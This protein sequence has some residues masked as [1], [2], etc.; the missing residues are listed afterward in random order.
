MNWL[1][2]LASSHFM[3]HGTSDTLAPKIL[4]EG[5]VPGRTLVWDQERAKEDE[6][7]RASYGGVYF[8]NNFMTA[9]SA[10]HTAVEQFGGKFLLV[11]A[12]LELRTPSILLDEDKLSNPIRAFNETL[13]VNANGW[14]YMDWVSAEMPDLDK[15]VQTYLNQISKTY[16]SVQKSSLGFQD[17]R[18]FEA[19][20]PQ[21][22]DF[23]I[24]AVMREIAI[25]VKRELKQGGYTSLLYRFPQFKDIDLSTQET[26]YRR[27]AN[28]LMQKTNFMANENVDSF[29]HNV[30][31]LDPVSFSGKNK[32]VLVSRIHECRHPDLIENK[33]Y[34]DAEIIYGNNSSAINLLKDGLTRLSSNMRIRSKNHIYVDQPK[35]NKNEL[36]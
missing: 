21:V 6:R 5:I 11:M 20:I 16:T 2:K 15:V 31:T 22:R 25:E 27:T 18:Q 9:C 33:Y 29:M 13:H 36:A 19:I 1:I 7:S 28:A 8:T 17:Q 24:A 30:R 23:I 32:I 35:E 34:V 26:E 14:Y 3:Y 12:Q 4:S 10:A